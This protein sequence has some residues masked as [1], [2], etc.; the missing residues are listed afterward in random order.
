METD[1]LRIG[2]VLGVVDAVSP[3]HG[4]HVG[5]CDRP[6]HH[7]VVPLGEGI[8]VVERVCIGIVYIILHSKERRKELPWAGE[9]S[10]GNARMSSFWKDYTLKY[11]K[12]RVR[13][14]VHFI[15]LLAEALSVK[16]RLLSFGLEQLGIETVWR[17]EYL[18]CWQNG[19]K[20]LGSRCCVGK[21][22]VTPTPGHDIDILS[23]VH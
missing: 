15:L 12:Q 18:R 9:S 6:S 20:V 11:L 5:L 14:R 21:L 4:L 1:G 17:G 22:L 19:R 3:A 13:I 23:V 7:R 16:R 2:N 8:L 10:F